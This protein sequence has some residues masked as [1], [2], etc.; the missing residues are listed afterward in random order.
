MTPKALHNVLDDAVALINL[1]RKGVT[2]ALFQTVLLSSPFTV[3]EWSTFLHL[4][5]RTLQRYKKENRVFEQPYS[6]RILEIARLQKRG[7]EVFGTQEMYNQWMESSVVALGGVHPKSF[8]DSSFGIRV[9]HDELTRIEH[10][11]LA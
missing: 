8:L 5:E 1:T 3:A 2:Y 7:A 9:L 4:T 6:D 10:G 11:V